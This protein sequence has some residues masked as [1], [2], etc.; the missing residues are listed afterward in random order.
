MAKRLTACLLIFALLLPL[1]G[2]W[3]YRSLDEV[4]LVVGLSIDY[5][6][7]RNLFLTG[8][9]IANLAGGEEMGPISGKMVFSEGKT[10]F[11]AVRNSKR[12]E[13]DRMFFGNT[14]VVIIDQQAAHDLG[15][16]GIVE[17]FLR[18]GE[19][20]ENMAIA[21]SQEDS[22]SKILTGGEDMKVIMSSV[23]ADIIREDPKVTSTAYSMQ[24]YEIYNSLYSPRRSALIPAVHMV[25]N[26]KDE[27]PEL[28]GTGVI[29]GDRLV[30][31]LSPEQS[32]YVLMVENK[33]KSGILTLSTSDI[34]PIDDLSLEI[35]FNK[36]KKSYTYE[37]GQFTFKIETDTYVA[38][39][40]NHARL[41]TSE[42]EVFLLVEADAERKIKENIEEL[43]S[44]LQ[45]Q[46]HTDVLGFGEMV[47]KK[48]HKLWREIEASWEDIFPTVK[49]EVSSNVRVLNSAF[50]T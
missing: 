34:V 10:L 8:F 41:D 18:D 45:H 22:A 24:L 19:T 33:L 23:L 37:N 7:K 38:I 36:A 26:G 35:F 47:S 28:N 1:G 40:E 31:Y 25:K 44:V 11:D 13:T 3:N 16:I 48:D 5:D 4:N 9:E 39:A 32:R 49:V 17:W 27:I 21:I 20:R 29:K 43:I 50:M 14:E 2:C 46:F 6:Q 30:G 15:V 12:R 42:P